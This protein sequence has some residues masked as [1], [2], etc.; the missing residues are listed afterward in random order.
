MY[1]AK[2]AKLLN[3]NAV[4]ALKNKFL[5]EIDNFRIVGELEM[6]Y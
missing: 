5:N 2:L 4:Q 3:N 6:R 1:E